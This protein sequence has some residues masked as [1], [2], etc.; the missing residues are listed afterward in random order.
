LINPEKE[1]IISFRVNRTHKEALKRYCE[2]KGISESE[3]CFDKLQPFFDVLLSVNNS[4]QS[5]EKR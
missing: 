2:F 1:A 5:E 3:Y 4:K